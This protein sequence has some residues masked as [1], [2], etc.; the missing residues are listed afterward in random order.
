MHRYGRRAFDVAA[1]LT[2]E[3]GLA[4][5]VVAGEPDLRVEFRYQRDHELAIYPDDHL[6]RRTRLG[7]FDKNGSEFFA[8]NIDI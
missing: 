4:A 7:L 8:K 2:E 1:Y 6:F 3:P 5:P